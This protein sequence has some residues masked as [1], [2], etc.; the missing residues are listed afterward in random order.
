MT[1]IAMS[2]EPGSQDRRFAAKLAHALGLRLTDVRKF[3]QDLAVAGGAADV[4]YGYLTS[5]SAAGKWKMSGQQLALRLQEEIL[6]TASCQR[7]LIVG[8][9]VP[10]ILRPLKHVIGVAVRAPIETRERNVMKELAYSDR[11]TARL[12][13]ESTD[14]MLS[15]FVRQV[16][17][18]DWH[19]PDHFD[20][21]VNADRTS[22]SCCVQLLKK[23]A[24]DARF[25]ETS[26]SRAAHASL[27]E[28][29]RQADVHSD[30]A[31]NPPGP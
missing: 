4:T 1:I 20:I 18:A 16:F 15:G 9:C 31:T 7:S 22:F 12:E 29:L 13:I 14:T 3:E 19:D 27:L 11:H 8:W 6:E 10:A 5:Q 21:V 24:K 25:Q 28:M 2:I 26:G 30:W 17:A 23:L